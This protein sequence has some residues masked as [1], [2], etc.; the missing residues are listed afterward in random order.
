MGA[1]GPIALVV[2]AVLLSGAAGSAASASD[3]SKLA[4]ELQ[5]DEKKLAEANKRL[6]AHRKKGLTTRDAIT[7]EEVLK[8]VVALEQ[9]HVRDTQAR[10]KKA[11]C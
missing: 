8:S 6:A 1:A 4:R 2:A 9:G 11:G 3:C 7:K 5:T 10:I